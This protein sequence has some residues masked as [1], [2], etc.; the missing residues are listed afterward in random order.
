MAARGGRR[1]WLPGSWRRG[2]ALVTGRRGA[3][4]A[5]HGPGGWRRE[6]RTR[7]CGCC[8]KPGARPRG[9]RA[10]RLRASPRGLQAVLRWAADVSQ[11]GWALAAGDPVKHWS[12]GVADSC[13]HSAVSKDDLDG[14]GGP[15]PISRR[16]YQQNTFPSNCASGLQCQPLPRRQP[17][18]PAGLCPASPQPR[19][20]GLDSRSFCEHVCV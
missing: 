7:A 17:A 18:G 4:R 9:E 15:Q 19:G 1:S 5:A 12:V 8:P 14:M 2:C 3:R 20:P 6:G 11:L 10:G 13:S 16:A